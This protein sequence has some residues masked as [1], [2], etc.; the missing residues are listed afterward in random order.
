M[1]QKQ[2]AEFMIDGR[3]PVRSVP[4]PLRLGRSIVMMGPRHGVAHV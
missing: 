4:L 3:A 2:A 1:W